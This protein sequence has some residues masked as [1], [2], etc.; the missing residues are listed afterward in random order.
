M[1]MCNVTLE[2]VIIYPIFKNNFSIYYFSLAVE[3]LFIILNQGSFDTLI[4]RE[5]K[6][7]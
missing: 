6:W 3:N 2:R 7:R 5:L 4:I 1:I